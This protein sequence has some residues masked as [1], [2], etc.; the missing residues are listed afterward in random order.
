MELKYL[1]SYKDVKKGEEKMEANKNEE[2][3]EVRDKNKLDYTI[4]K[5]CNKEFKENEMV[6]TII[7][8][9][10]KENNVLVIEQVVH[11]QCAVGSLGIKTR[12]GS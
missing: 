11:I 12:E 8:K 6:I 1:Y 2:M 10:N 4:C 7:G 9:V 3:V 5:M